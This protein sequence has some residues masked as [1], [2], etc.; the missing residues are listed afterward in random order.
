MRTYAQTGSRRGFTLVELLV[1]ITIM[2]ILIAL[3]LPA[4]AGAWNLAQNLKCQTNLRQ[5]ASA[6]L[7]YSAD[8]K[9]AIV[10]TKFAQSGLYWCDTLVRGN[11]L[12]ANNTYDQGSYPSTETG[13]LRCPVSEISI[14]SETP[15]TDPTAVN[16][17]GTARLGN[18]TFA[19]DCSYFWNGYTG[20]DTTIMARYPSLVYDENAVASV[21]AYQTHDLSEIKLRSQTVMVADGVLFDGQT[22]P[23]RIAAR[24]PGD[25]GRRCR[26]NVAF[27]D[28]HTESIDRY[29]DPTWDKES[30]VDST[31]YTPIMGRNP[32]LDG[33]NA[34]YTKPP[35]FKLPLR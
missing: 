9:G 8:N 29:P 7:N 18:T 19:V 21:R 5:I 12:T 26:T 1:V 16:V 27:F 20:T 35:Y 6:G 31:S 14:V 11:Y 2:G 3:L 23:A 22:N 30:V 13:V 17:L 32:V 10:P 34:N 33:P 28:G 24:H 15:V 4:L 25:H